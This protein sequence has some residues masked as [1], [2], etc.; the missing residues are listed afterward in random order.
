MVSPVCSADGPGTIALAS[1]D[2]A[3]AW[4]QVADQNCAAC[5]LILRVSA[6]IG[7]LTRGESSSSAARR[8]RA[9]LCWRPLPFR[10][11]SAFASIK[12]SC[13]ARLSRAAASTTAK[14]RCRSSTSVAPLCG[15]GRR[16]RRPRVNS[17]DAPLCG[18]GGA[19]KAR[20]A[21][22]RATPGVGPVRF[23]AS[24]A[25]EAE[26][27]GAAA[28]CRPPQNGRARRRG[29]GARPNSRHTETRRDWRR[30]APLKDRASG[31]GCRGEVRQGRVQRIGVQRV[32][33]RLLRGTRGSS[34]AGLENMPVQS[35]CVVARALPCSRFRATGA[36]ARAGAKF[37]RA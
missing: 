15:F 36:A 1:G 20:R 30:G 27:Q 33:A 12:R 4:P 23:V 29:F 13:C 17:R 6:I 14:S 19:D 24:F 26:R 31:A 25:P 16:R 10:A 7:T 21:A 8:G 2:F 18:R 22:G 32:R 34:K 9:E 5:G 35:I 3:Q 37:P 11:K 28:G